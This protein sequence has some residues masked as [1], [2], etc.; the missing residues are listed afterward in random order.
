MLQQKYKIAAKC[1]LRRFACKIQVLFL[2]QIREVLQISK[3]LMDALKKS[4][5]LTGEDCYLV[6]K[7]PAVLP[8][9]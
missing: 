9:E 5:F 8:L 2:S 7:V 3:D 4:D 1:S 6:A